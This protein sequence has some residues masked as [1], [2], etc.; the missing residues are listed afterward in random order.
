MYIKVSQVVPG[1]ILADVS[2]ED[3]YGGA[4]P[5]GILTGK[6]IFVQGVAGAAEGYYLIVKIYPNGLHTFNDTAGA[7][8]T[9]EKWVLVPG[10]AKK[11]DPLPDGPSNRPRSTSLER[12]GGG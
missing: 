5:T 1:G 8:R 7:R 2:M 6:R 11:I 10:T 4:A 12:I 9:I 3:Y